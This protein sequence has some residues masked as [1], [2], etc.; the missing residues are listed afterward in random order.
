MK[1]NPYRF[2]QIFHA[3]IHELMKYANFNEKHI[4]LFL[5]KISRIHRDRKQLNSCQ[6]L[7]Q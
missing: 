2:Y 4:L 7:G 3:K 6:E 5:C 1:L